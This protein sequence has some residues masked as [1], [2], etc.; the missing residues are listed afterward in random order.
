M[1]VSLADFCRI[2]Q[3]GVLSAHRSVK[4]RC[5]HKRDIRDDIC[6]FLLGLCNN[7]AEKYDKK[8]G[9]RLTLALRAEQ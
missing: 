3:P 7:I 4:F 1:A 6:R 8:I 9:N 5:G 2:G